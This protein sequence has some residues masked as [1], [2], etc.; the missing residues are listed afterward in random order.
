MRKR[1]SIHVVAVFVSV[2]CVTGVRGQTASNVETASAPGVSLDPSPVVGVAGPESFE[3]C[4][5]SGIDDKGTGVRNGRQGVVFVDDDAPPGGDGV[6]WDTAFKYLQDALAVVHAGDEI[7]VAGGTYAPD[8]D[9]SGAV[10]P[11]DRAATFQLVSGVRVTGGYAGLS[12]PADPDLRD[13]ELYETTLTGDLSGNDG[14][15]FSNRGDNSYHVMTGSGTDATAVIEGC[16]ITAGYADTE[17]FGGGM[18]NDG[19]SPSILGCNFTQN[20]ARHGA[21]MYNAMSDPTIDGCAFLDNR[22][23]LGVSISGGGG[24]YNHESNPHIS[25]CTF[26]GNITTWNRDGG[27]IQN[28]RSSPTIADCTFTNNEG[29]AGGAIFNDDGSSPFITRCRFINNRAP[30]GGGAIANLHLCCPTV[31]DSLFHG[32]V[33]E[34]SRALSGWGGAIHEDP[35]E[36]CSSSFINC[37][38]SGNTTVS[39]GGVIYIRSGSAEF[40]NCTFSENSADISGGAFWILPWARPILTNCILRGNSPNVFDGDPDDPPIVRYTNIEGGFAGIGNIDIDPLFVD[41]DGDDDVPGT[42]DDDLR[43]SSGSPCIDAGDNSV[44]SNC[45][46]DLDGNIRFMDDLGTPDSG[47]GT[48]PILDMGAY[49]FIGIASDCNGNDVHDDCDIDLGTSDDC[50]EDLTPDDC[51]LTGNDCDNDLVPDDCQL[52][53]GDCDGNG[54]LDECDPGEDCNANGVPDICEIADETSED[55]D[56]NG[57]PD[58]CQPDE[59]CN[60]NDIQDICDIADG[61]S[62]DCNSNWIPDECDIATGGSAD[63]NGN[64]V[65]DDCEVPKNRYISLVTRDEAVPL[66]Y[67][68]DMNSSAYFPGSVGTL[69]WVG[70]P[71]ENNH[72]RVVDASVYRG[73]WPTVVYVGDCEIVPVATYEIWATSDGATF[74]DPQEVPTIRKPGARYY[75]DVVGSGTGNLPPLPGFT[76]PNRVVNVTDVQAFLLTFQGPTSPSVHT[77][78]VDQHGLGDG[79]P[80]NFMLN[81]SDLQ[82]ILWGIAGQE[83]LDSPEHLDPADC[84]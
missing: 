45:A 58:E 76:P 10:S 28:F 7:H 16:T 2:L 72:S 70:E 20:S 60:V 69:G 81:V 21:G 53:D 33:T 55:C 64:A 39:R 14:P 80:P 48:A 49:E 4:N 8:L 75:G 79:V 40:V 37:T 35:W 83:Y 27:G 19:G 29:D 25:G 36:N 3:N 68:V 42:L 22:A 84:P 78:W 32:N 30:R 23:D 44:L 46:R 9:E 41:A 52:A 26:D 15:D 61:T 56:G 12:N 34:G 63:D 67:R 66:A 50:N 77:T 17:S 1:N 47:S 82:R 24:M 38:F 5:N 6:G 11:G 62:G 57:I 13:T 74:T 43:L 18:Y 51:Q 73:D 71:D 59:D 54:V 31:I 65:P